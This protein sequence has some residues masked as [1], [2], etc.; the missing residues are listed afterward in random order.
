M[1]HK[2]AEK[3]MLYPLNVQGKNKALHQICAPLYTQDTHYITSNL[4]NIKL[5]FI[6]Q[7][8]C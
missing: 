1:F 3:K 6:V 7:L 8:N 2:T 5:L 4:N